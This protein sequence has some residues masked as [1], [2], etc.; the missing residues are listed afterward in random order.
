MIGQTDRA[1]E[2]SSSDNNVLE[3]V[4]GTQLETGGRVQLTGGRVVEMVA[5][6]GRA[7]SSM[8]D[9]STLPPA[10]SLRRGEE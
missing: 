1:V 2:A 6:P 4:P 10:Y 7:R 3:Y 5:N 9:G 8:A